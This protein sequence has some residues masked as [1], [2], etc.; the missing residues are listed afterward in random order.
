MADMVGVRSWVGEK[1]QKIR[2]RSPSFEAQRDS[3]SIAGLDHPHSL[4]L[5]SIRPSRTVRP[6]LS[7]HF[8][9][10]LTAAIFSRHVC[11]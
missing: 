6:Q 3:R 2:R 10:F 1:E 9:L 11:Q 5:L 4:Q 8:A 7:H